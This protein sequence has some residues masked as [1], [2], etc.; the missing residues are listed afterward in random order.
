M[1]DA[2][3]LHLESMSQQFLTQGQPILMGK[4]NSEFHTLSHMGFLSV[5]DHGE[6][7]CRSVRMHL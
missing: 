7:G 1:N 5:H 6:S 2:E 4:C 3:L